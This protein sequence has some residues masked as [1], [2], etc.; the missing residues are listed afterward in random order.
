TLTSEKLSHFYLCEYGISYVALR[1]GNVYGPRQNAHGE[2]GVIAIFT[3]KLLAGHRVTIHGDGLQTRDYVYVGD[4]ARANLAA[5]NFTGAPSAFN[6]GTGIET[7]VV[8]LHQKLRQAM[9]FE[10]PAIHGPGKPGEQRRSVL[11]CTRAMRELA[12]KPEVNLDDGLGKTVD[13]F[14]SSKMPD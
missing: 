10:Q 3:Q 8:T 5:L 1:Y 13:W 7:D 12:W 14:A 6:V 11:D 9:G 2:A 4:V